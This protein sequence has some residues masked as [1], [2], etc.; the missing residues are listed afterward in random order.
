MEKRRQFGPLK[1]LGNKFTKCN[2]QIE[3]LLENANAL[4]G[5]N[6]QL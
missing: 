1:C 3:F 6:G 2:R 4:C 5:R